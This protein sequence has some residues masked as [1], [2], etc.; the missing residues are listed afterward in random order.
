MMIDSRY[1]IPYEETKIYAAYPI[2]PDIGAD[3][4]ENAYFT[5]SI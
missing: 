4:A 2:Y 5:W 3:F 1:F